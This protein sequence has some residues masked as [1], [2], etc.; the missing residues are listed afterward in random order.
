MSTLFLKK[1]QFFLLFFSCLITAQFLNGR[2]L[3]VYNMKQ[4]SGPVVL[5]YLA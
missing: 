5:L 1:N 2:F 4:F 3:A